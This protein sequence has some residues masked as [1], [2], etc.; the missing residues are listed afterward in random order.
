MAAQTN[1][2]N[3]KEETKPQYYG[4]YSPKMKMNQLDSKRLKLDSERTSPNYIYYKDYED[5][6]V[7]IT[8]VSK[9]KDHTLKWDDI[10]FVGELKEFYKGTREPI[11]NGL[12][13]NF[14]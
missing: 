3:V 1:N 7:E 6:I 2:E 12:K 5:N 9:K 8:F 14:I 13:K 10:V 4:F 11:K